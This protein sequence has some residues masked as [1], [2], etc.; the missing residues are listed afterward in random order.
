MT[1]TVEV[2][3]DRLLATIYDDLNPWGGAGRILSWLGGRAGGLR[4]GLEA[5]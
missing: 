4:K 2:F 1:E 5:G 3:E